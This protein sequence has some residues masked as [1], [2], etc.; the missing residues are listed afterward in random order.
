M[1]EQ[2]RYMLEERCLFL[3]TFKKEQAKR[4]RIRKKFKP[5]VRG[6]SFLWCVGEVGQ[7]RYKLKV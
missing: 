6:V 2:K 4:M 3:L 1:S 5:D 7:K